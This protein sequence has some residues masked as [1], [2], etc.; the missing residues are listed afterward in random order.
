MDQHLWV[1][2]KLLSS[3]LHQFIR[4]CTDIMFNCICTIYTCFYVK[5]CFYLVVFCTFQSTH[6]F[7]KLLVWIAIVLVLFCTCPSCG[8]S[9]L[10]VLRCIT[11]MW[12]ILTF[13]C[14]NYDINAEDPVFWFFKKIL[15]WITL[16]CKLCVYELMEAYSTLFLD[17]LIICSYACII[18]KQAWCELK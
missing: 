16:K 4:G 5:N 9:D 2:L 1:L 13:S 15:W 12:Y 6:I 8:Y 3:T 18:V 11:C 14:Y 17:I 7:K 10:E